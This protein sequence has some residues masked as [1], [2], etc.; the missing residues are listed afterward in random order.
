CK[1]LHPFRPRSRLLPWPPGCLHHFVSHPAK[2]EGIGL[3]D[4]FD[5]VTM[6]VF[7]REN[8]PMIAAAVQRD[9]D[10]ITKRA[11]YARVSPPFRHSRSRIP[12]RW[13]AST[14][15]FLNIVDTM[16]P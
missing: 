15:G 16:K 12:Q 11:H 10:G 1:G 2:E 5:R 8:C 3:V 6:Q 4:V 9:V 7:V 14:Y 13:S